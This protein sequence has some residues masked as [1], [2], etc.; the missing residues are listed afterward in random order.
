MDPTADTSRAIGPAVAGT[1]YPADPGELASLVESL[2][3][4]ADVAD[5][6]PDAADEPVPRALIV[7]HA[8]LVYSG[9]VAARA[10]RLLRPAAKRL[11]R[12]VLLGPSHRVPLRGLAVPRAGALATPLG[13]VPVDPDLKAR[14]LRLGIVG[15]EDLAHAWEHCLEVQL[16]F[17][18]SVLEDFTV[19]PVV[20]G[21][22][23][24]RA[25]L[26][27]LESLPLEE[28]DTLL[29]VSSDLSHFHDY[30]S[31]R[32]LDADTVDEILR[33][34]PDELDGYRA[35]GYKGIRGLLLWARGHGMAARL[36]DLRNSGDTAGDRSQVVGYASI[37]FD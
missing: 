24:D 5:P 27:L 36:V 33:L 14:A 6:A 17:L 4:D 23:T 15:E 13:T 34:A 8:G 26:E 9:P 37:A 19:L 18:Q 21:E 31:A 20:V 2:L 12:V 35:C 28:P 1:F 25:V 10:Y 16:P 11:R 7:P 29:L 22:S 3:R 30:A 32:R